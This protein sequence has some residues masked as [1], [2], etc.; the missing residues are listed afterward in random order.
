MGSASNRPFF[1]TKLR[2]C[3]QKVLGWVLHA[4]VAED[5]VNRICR[6]P[7]RKRCFQGLPEERPS[8][9]LN[10][11]GS[12]A[13]CQ[14]AVAIDF[15]GS[16]RPVEVD[17]TTNAPPRVGEQLA[18]WVQLESLAERFGNFAGVEESRAEPERLPS[19]RQLLQA[20]VQLLA[21]VGD[22]DGVVFR[23]DDGIAVTSLLPDPQAH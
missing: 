22:E 15:G 7:L 14:D 16:Q 19:S 11:S 9:F 17:T 2:L 1:D 8:A 12:R 18:L 4:Q 20:P 6:F 5:D 10:H 3:R 13:T 23:E 21:E